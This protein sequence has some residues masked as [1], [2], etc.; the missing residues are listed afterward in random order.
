MLHSVID[1]YKSPSSFR[2]F[3]HTINDLDAFSNDKSLGN[4]LESCNTI[5]CDNGIKINQKKPG[6]MKYA[7]QKLLQKIVSIH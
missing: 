1:K 7:Y 3:S 2:I 5:N 4:P 6:Y